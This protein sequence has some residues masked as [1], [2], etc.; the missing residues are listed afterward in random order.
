M[1]HH[2]EGTAASTYFFYLKLKSSWCTESLCSRI[3]PWEQN[4][5]SAQSAFSSGAWQASKSPIDHLDAA[6]LGLYSLIGQP[7]PISRLAVSVRSPSSADLMADP[8]LS[9]CSFRLM[10][11]RRLL[12]DDERPVAIGGRAMDLLIA[13]VEGA[14]K[15]LS[16]HEL[17]RRVWSGMTVEES[18]LKVQISVIRRALGEGQSGNRCIVTVPRRGYTFVAPIKASL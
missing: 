5:S 1:G 14:G 13:L 7:F 15:V 3:I 2:H 11:T 10:P 9:F 6:P 16:K 12:L 18:N 17:M 4:V 8:C